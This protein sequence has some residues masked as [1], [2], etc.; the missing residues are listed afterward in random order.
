[1]DKA[2]SSLWQEFK[3][4]DRQAF[5]IIYDRYF[6]VVF[7]YCKQVTL[8]DQLIEDTIHDLFITLWDRRQRLGDVTSIK[9]YLIIASRRNL[10]HQLK[11][12]RVEELPDHLSIP[13][14]EF[15]TEQTQLSSKV[16]EALQ[17]LNE[18]HREVLYLKFYN[19]LSFQEISEI[20]ELKVDTIYK[21]VARSLSKLRKELPARRFII[22][23]SVALLAM[24]ISAL[25][26]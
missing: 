24:T 1:M 13:P 7:Q 9:S 6:P 22:I 14:F 2:D 15:N 26:I 8:D 12:R 21:M 16:L 23:S 11:E 5:L 3:C 18:Q 17:T 25:I 20:M 19:N 10:I 4:G